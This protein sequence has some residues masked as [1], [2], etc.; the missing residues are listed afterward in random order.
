MSNKLVT[1]WIG[2]VRTILKSST[3]NASLKKQL[4]DTMKALIFRRSKAGKQVGR[5]RSEIDLPKLKSSYVEQRVRL[6]QSGK[7]SSST[8]PGKSNV[9]KTGEMLEDLNVDITNTGAIVNLGNTES[10]EKMRQLENRRIM[11]ATKKDIV[12]LTKLVERSIVS[13]L[14]NFKV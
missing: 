5:G 3:G 2:L 6:Q 8:S 12:L 7:L 4:G 13:A 14:K 1:V 9:T 10:E 11:D